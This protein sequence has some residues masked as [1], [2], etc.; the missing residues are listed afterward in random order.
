MPKRRKLPEEDLAASVADMISSPITRVNLSFL[1]PE[2][3]PA[4]VVTGPMGEGISVAPKPK[5]VSATP[6]EVVPVQQSLPL[7]ASKIMWQVERL[8]TV[9]ES[10]SRLRRIQSALDALSAVEEKVYRLLWGTPEE[11]QEEFRLVQFSLQR[12]SNEACINIKTVREMIPRL[13][14]K[15]FLEIAAE[16]DV[17]RNIPTTYRVW[18]LAAILSRLRRQN[19]FYVIRTGKGVLYAHPMQA[20]VSPLEPTGEE[21][22]GMG[23]GKPTPRGLE[24]PSGGSVLEDLAA[25]CRDAFGVDPDRQTLASMVAECQENAIQTTGEPATGA[26]VLHF[27]AMRAEVMRKATNIRNHVAVLRK[28]LPG[29]FTGPAYRAYRSAA[30][31]LAVASNRS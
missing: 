5:G 17:R 31:E 27:A 25:L 3:K 29:C 23:Q 21:T 19:R 4:G 30:S 8:G 24:L 6:P 1:Q 16:A 9:F 22:I 11:G 18:G 15:G 28:A 13:I 26:E 2:T 10:G 12:I 7:P 20:M 14:E